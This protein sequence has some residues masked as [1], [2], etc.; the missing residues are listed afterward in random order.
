M[1]ADLW[2][3][4]ARI[5]TSSKSYTVSTTV[6]RILL[7]LFFCVS[8]VLKLVSVDDFE[9]YI[10]SFG[11]AAFDLCSLAARAVIIGEMILGLGLISGW[12]HN[13]V[14]SVTA[15]LLVGFSGFLIWRMSVGDEGSCHCFGILV[16]MNPAQSLL[17]N[18]VAL[19]VLA[20]AWSRPTELFAARHDDTSGDRVPEAGEPSRTGAQ[21]FAARLYRHKGTV[22][23]VISAVAAL[24][25]LIIN[26]PDLWFRWTRG[27][28]DDLNV[29][30]FRRYADSTGVSSGRK[31]VCFYSINCEH[32]RR[33]AAKM[34][35]II[36]RNAI[37]EESVFCFFMQEYVDMTEAV[38]IFFDN[39]GEGLHLPYHWIYPLR[40]IPLTNGAMPLVCLF[41]DGR[42][43][44]EYDRLTIDEAAISEF[45]LPPLKAYSANTSSIS[46]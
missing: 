3:L 29:S 11:F 28:S 35:G 34:A 24:A 31:V 26:P 36:R 23:G 14:N 21:R 1:P 4:T 46:R 27:E 41:D 16:E 40:F 44:K 17:K 45:I 12:W 30:E 38:S 37:P 43:I 19:A 2:T 25:I 13:F 9:L 42:L 15:A 5:I 33:C 32:C 7:G 22:A 6:L 10:F 18:A 20:F 8:A 39:Y